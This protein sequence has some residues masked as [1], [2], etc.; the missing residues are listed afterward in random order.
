MLP[1]LLLELLVDYPARRFGR[2]SPMMPASPSVPAPMLDQ[3]SLPAGEAMD[4]CKPPIFTA[5]PEDD[6]EPWIQRPAL[7]QRRITSTYWQCESEG[8]HLTLFEAEKIYDRRRRRSLMGKW[9]PLTVKPNINRTRRG[10]DFADDAT[11]AK[12]AA[13]NLGTVQS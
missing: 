4:Y 10:V 1:A 5:C 6:E 11:L 7:R 8:N 9:C 3:T 12:L 13:G 2:A